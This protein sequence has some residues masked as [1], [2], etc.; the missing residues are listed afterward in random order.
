MTKINEPLDCFE[1]EMYQDRLKALKSISNVM[2]YINEILLEKIKDKKLARVQEYITVAEPA[3]NDLFEKVERFLPEKG[4]LPDRSKAKLSDLENG[5]YFLSDYIRLLLIN[6]R[7]QSFTHSDFHI[8]VG[9]DEK[10]KIKKARGFIDFKENEASDIYKR[11]KVVKNYSDKYF[12][13]ENFKDYPK[14]KSKKYQENEEVDYI[15]TK[16]YAAITDADIR[17]MYQTLKKMI[18]WSIY[19]DKDVNI[20]KDPDLYSKKEAGALDGFVANLSKY[21]INQIYKLLFVAGIPMEHSVKILDRCVR[22]INQPFFEKYAHTENRNAF[23]YEASTIAKKLKP[24]KKL[25]KEK[26]FEELIP[27]D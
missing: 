18:H 27:E 11:L 1:D 4:I 23:S 6:F 19:N 21:Y 10:E 5:I 12:N 9:H 24:T 20:L 22:F 2:T 3:K 13:R 14:F 25:Y 17:Q 26:S 15:N 8:R 16:P 7:I